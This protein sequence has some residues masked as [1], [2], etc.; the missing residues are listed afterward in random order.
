M[1]AK[2]KKKKKMGLKG[3]KMDF[4][5]KFF[6]EFR[7]YKKVCD[8]NFCDFAPLFEWFFVINENNL[9]GENRQ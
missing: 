4:A 7:L 5:T 3:E 6:C 2:K 9:G 1:F 8:I